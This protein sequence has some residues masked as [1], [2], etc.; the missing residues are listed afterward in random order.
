MIKLMTLRGWII[1]DYLMGTKPSYRYPC[2]EGKGRRHWRKEGS[3]AR[4]AK[5]GVMGPQA[6]N[7]C[8]SPPP[9]QTAKGDG[10]IFL[11]SL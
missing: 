5:A 7:I 6:K 2:R 9:P 11:Q 3:V 4:Q 10:W 8:S 1:L